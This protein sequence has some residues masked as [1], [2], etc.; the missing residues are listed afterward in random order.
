MTARAPGTHASSAWRLSFSSAFED[1]RLSSKETYVD[2]VRHGPYEWYFESG[3]LFEEGTYT[4]GVLDG[5]YRAFWETGDLYEEGTYRSG[6]FDGPRRWFMNGRLVEMVTYRNGVI[7]GIYE[8]YT[9]WG[10]LDIEWKPTFKQSR[11][12]PPSNVPM[13]RATPAT[14][15]LPNSC[16]NCICPLIALGL[17]EFVN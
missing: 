16:I 13:D 8:R 3:S 15:A 5:P 12:Q 14:R 2:G 7:E 10:D 1:R 17:S 4:E 11:T 9:P 6:Q